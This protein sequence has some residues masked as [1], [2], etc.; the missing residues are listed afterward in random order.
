MQQDKE[1][2]IQEQ[3][4]AF[5]KMDLLGLFSEGI[6]S[7]EQ[8]EIAKRCIEKGVGERVIKK[9]IHPDNTKEKTK[10]M[11]ELAIMLA[12]KTARLREEEGE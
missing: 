8:K 7:P 1:K 3:R 9:V 10:E 2:Q 12:E 4:E 5:N 6:L 11:E